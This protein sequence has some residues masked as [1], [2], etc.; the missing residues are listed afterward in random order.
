MEGKLVRYKKYNRLI[1]VKQAWFLSVLGLPYIPHDDEKQLW[2]EQLT[3]V[4]TPTR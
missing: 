4:S 2:G 3:M 1:P